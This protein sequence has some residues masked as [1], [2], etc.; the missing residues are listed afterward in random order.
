MDQ[1]IEIR[2]VRKSDFLESEF[3]REKRG[4]L[5]LFAK[6]LFIATTAVLANICLLLAIYQAGL[7]TAHEL[8]S[9]TVTG[10]KG[11]TSVMRPT[12]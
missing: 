9:I 2:R 1:H 10:L 4:R 6:R 11:G 5:F 8:V 12:G 3:R 7:V